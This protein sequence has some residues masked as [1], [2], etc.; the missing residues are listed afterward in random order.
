MIQIFYFSSLDLMI[1]VEYV[2]PANTLRYASHREMESDERMTVEQYIMA[3]M[4]PK[5]E[6][7]L[8]QS[9]LFAYLG[10][11][12]RLEKKL[13]RFQQASASN[14]ARRKERDITAS[15][16]SLINVSM[17]NYYTE[18]IG[19]LILSARSELKD[20]RQF[21]AQRASL[22]QQMN[23]LVQAY[24]VYADNKVSLHEIIPSELKPYWPELEEA[25]YFA[26]SMQ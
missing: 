5:T 16:A 2:K 26:A 3:Q 12:K 25:R 8:E 9:S 14:S 1:K 11:D 17:R 13:A 15:V 24:N 20:G 7:F 22:K 21:E 10:M 18:K 23:D 4:A 6:Y 19:E